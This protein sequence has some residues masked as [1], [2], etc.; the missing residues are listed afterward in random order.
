MGKGWFRPKWQGV[1]PWSGRIWNLS[2]L[3]PGLVFAFDPLEYG[4]KDPVSGTILPFSADSELVCPQS[5][6]SRKIFGADEAAI[7]TYGYLTDGPGTQYFVKPQ[8]PTTQT[9]SL[10]STSYYTLSVAGTGSAALSANTAS[11]STTGTA[12]EGSDVTFEVTSTG[13]VDVTITDPLD[14][15]QLEDGQYSSTRIYN[16]GTPGD[17]STSSR[18]TRAADSAGNGLQ[19]V[20]SDLHSD[21]QKCFDGTIG[22]LTLLFGWRPAF[23]YSDVDNNGGILS[24]NSHMWNLLYFHLSNGL[25]WHDDSNSAIH[26]ISFSKN[27]Y[28]DIVCQ[29]YGSTLRIKTRKNGGSWSGW[30]TASYDGAFTTGDTLQYFFDNQYPQWLRFMEMFNYQLIESEID[31]RVGK[32]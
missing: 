30:T 23:D 25:Y 2:V 21:V 9:I 31:N 8:D 14:W 22:E 1:F 19:P 5:D 28:F 15:C 12:T 20:L 6:G 13:T 27:D 32:Y 4:L 7:G 18:A 17:G 11:I 29:A 26:I 10:P 24:S 16:D 3:P